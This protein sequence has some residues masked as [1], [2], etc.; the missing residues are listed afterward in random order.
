MLAIFSEHR[1]THETLFYAHR[2]T[3]ETLSYA[4][5]T[6]RETLH[7]HQTMWVTMW[8]IILEDFYAK[9]RGTIR[10]PAIKVLSV[11]IQVV[12]T[13]YCVSQTIL[14]Q[15]VMV[16]LRTSHA[17]LRQPRLHSPEHIQIRLQET[18]LGTTQ[19]GV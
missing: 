14:E 19:V 5:Q 12:M 10:E 18:I 16:S 2:L 1:L 6:I 4:L 11:T 8:A 17:S 15:V 9:A 7:A 13:L 3:H